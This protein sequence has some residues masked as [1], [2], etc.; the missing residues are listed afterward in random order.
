MIEPRRIITVCSQG[1][2]RS[3]ALA[4]VL[5]LHFEPVDVL[6]IGVNGNSR[7]TLHMLYDWA[8]CVIAMHQPVLDIIERRVKRWIGDNPFP[9]PHYLCDVGPDS[10]H[11][12]KHPQLI[13]RVWRWAREH[14]EVLGIT[15][16]TRKI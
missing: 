9:I 5:K 2:C 11:N 8:H 4:D 15:E 7:E 1:L 10:Y 6:P 13:D 14:S 3:V 12:P 16:H